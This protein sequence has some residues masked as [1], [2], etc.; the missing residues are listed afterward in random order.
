MPRYAQIVGWGKAL[1]SRVMTN[2]EL[3]QIVSTSD[4]WIRTR[5]GIRARRIAGPRE[6]TASLAEQA[7]Q[8]AIEDCGHSPRAH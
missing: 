2:G 7:A 4:E 6:T 8:A 3:S 5:T 1:P